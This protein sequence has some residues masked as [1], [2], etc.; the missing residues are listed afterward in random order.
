MIG[1]SLSGWI[2][3]IHEDFN[4]N[5]KIQPPCKLVNSIE[6]TIY[7]FSL[8]RPC[9]TRTIPT[10]NATRRDPYTQRL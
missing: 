4:F 3:V 8:P 9:L 10:G 1:S 7:M 2:R 6:V 5:A